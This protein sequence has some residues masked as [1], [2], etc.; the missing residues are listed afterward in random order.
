MMQFKWQTAVRVEPSRRPIS[1]ADAILLMGSCFTEAMSGRLADRSF[2]TVVNPLGIVYN[3]ISMADGLCRVLSGSPLGYQDLVFQ[4]DLWHSWQHH[5][6]FSRP[7]RQA[8][9][10]ACN[11]ALNEA[12]NYLSSATTLILTFGTAHVYEHEDYGLVAN[13]HKVPAS[14]FSKRR[15]SVMEIVDRW[16]AVFALLPTSVRHVVL[17]V[18]PVRHW[19]DGA[20]SDRLSKATLLL[21][22]EQLTGATDQLLVEYFPAYELLQDELRDYRFYADDMLHP[23]SQAEEYIWNRFSENYMTEPTR[24]LCDRV[25]QLRRLERHR[26]MQADAPSIGRYQAQLA[27][28]RTEVEQLLRDARG[29]G[30]VQD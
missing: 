4:V 9:L 29:A 7:S 15:L 18:S 16:R 6:R 25:M 26:P 8:C 30:S 21:A 28:L 24:L 23:S 2:S 11:A 1:H 19:A 17:T 20:H 5:S 13:C 14:Q 3:P 27:A 12:H 22:A 10:D